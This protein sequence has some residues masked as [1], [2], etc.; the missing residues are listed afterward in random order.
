[1]TQ[2]A[3]LL[4]TGTEPV[5]Y[6][7][8][9]DGRLAEEFALFLNAEVDPARVFRLHSVEGELLGFWRHNKATAMDNRERALDD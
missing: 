1:M 5:L 8:I 2:W 6:G 7:P 3:V 9:D 4:D